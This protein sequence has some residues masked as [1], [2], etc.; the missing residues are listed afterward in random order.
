[1]ASTGPVWPV[2]GN[3][4]Q[5]WSRISSLNEL[6]HFKAQL[7]DLGLVYKITACTTLWDKIG[8]ISSKVAYNDPVFVTMPRYNRLGPCLPLYYHF[9]AIFATLGQ[10][11]PYYYQGARYS[12]K[13][14]SMV[15]NHTKCPLIAR[16]DQRWPH[17]AQY[18]QFWSICDKC[19]WKGYVWLMTPASGINCII[20]HLLVP[21]DLL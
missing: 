17:L 1:M 13:W 15:H 11:W 12:R 21:Y 7:S 14:P 4:S 8:Q 10:V 2:V 16:C 3:A 20:W 19:E 9:W 5:L 6:D 18:S